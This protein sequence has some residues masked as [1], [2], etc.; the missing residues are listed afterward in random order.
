MN[1]LSGSKPPGSPGGQNGRRTCRSI[2]LRFGLSRGPAGYVDW[3]FDDTGGDA[4]RT[5]R[6]LREAKR[7]NRAGSLSVRV[8][9]RVN[10]AASANVTL[11]SQDGK[12]RNSTTD[13]E[14]KAEFGAVAPGS[15][16]I[17][18]SKEGYRAGDARSVRI[19]PGSCLSKGAQMWP[20]RVRS[21][22]F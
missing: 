3:V 17:E 11:V 7:V 2:W 8:S 21:K 5:V 14:G 13:T 1:S 22:G 4:I 12:R 15:G 10:D 20:E 18:V 19:H 9:D 6:Y 16:T